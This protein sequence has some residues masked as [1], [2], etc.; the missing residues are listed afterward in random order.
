MIRA[1][2]ANSRMQLEN[3]DRSA[4]SGR[5]VLWGRTD[6]SRTGVLLSTRIPRLTGVTVEG[7]PGL[8]PRGARD[9]PAGRPKGDAI[10]ASSELEPFGEFEW[11]RCGAADPRHRISVG[12][13]VTPEQRFSRT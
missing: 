7:L 1:S 10:A 8:R 2:F 11:W 3:G 9:V 6:P 4:V 12:L 13:G 5:T